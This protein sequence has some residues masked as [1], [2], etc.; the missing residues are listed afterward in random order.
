MVLGGPMK[1]LVFTEKTDYI[2]VLGLLAEEIHKDI[3]VEVISECQLANACVSDHHDLVVIDDRLYHEL[4]EECLDALKKT[5]VDLIVLLGDRKNVKRYLNFNLL[6]YF[7][8]PLNWEHIDERLKKQFKRS[9]A[10]DHIEHKDE[11]PQKYL[12]KHKSRVQFIDYADILYF[13][14]HDKHVHVHT[15]H[16][17][18][19]SNE[20]LKKLIGKLPDEFI[21]VHSAFIVNFDNARAIR[22]TGNRSYSIAFK[23]YEGVAT[24]SRKR[25]NELMQDTMKRYR[26]SYIEENKK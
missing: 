19:E 7:V 15:N 26:L 14:K 20:S 22:S 16:K 6:D 5:Q 23:S 8:S 21:R 17:V 11:R 25:A 4:N 1:I 13:E 24:M 10:L 18:Y 3:D 12:L 2:K 9:S